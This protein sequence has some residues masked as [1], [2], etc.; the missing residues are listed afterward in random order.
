ML[1]QHTKGGG[2]WY[3]S[4]N[5]LRADGIDA[6][7]QLLDYFVVR[8]QKFSL[9]GILYTDRP[10][11]YSY[12]NGFNLLGVVAFLAGTVAYFAVYDHIAGVG[13]M[14]LFYLVTGTGFS[15]IVAGLVYWLGSKIPAVN[16][17]LLKDRTAPDLEAT[18]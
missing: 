3:G 5:S 16:A 18:A 2:V 10:G 13:R 1:T 11:P 15:C 12:T 4:E 8:K 9:R 7:T 6:G 14:D 17:Y